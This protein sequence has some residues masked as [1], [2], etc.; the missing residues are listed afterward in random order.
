M[1]INVE[2]EPFKGQRYEPGGLLIWGF[3]HHRRPDEGDTAD[4]TD[5]TINCL[6]L[7][8]KHWFFNR[9]RR[10]FGDKEAHQ[11]W[12]GVAF[13]N[14]LPTAVLSSARFSGGSAEQRG[15]VK[16]RV[17]R[18]LTDLRPGRT[19]LFSTKGW[20]MWPELNGSVPEPAQVLMT[21]PELQYGTYDFGT[22]AEIKAFN[23]P[24]PMFQNDEA[25]TERVHHLMTR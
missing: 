20:P 18:I 4:F 9:I 8:G 3:S 16:Q 19:V 17:R 13:A 22:G 7:S 15:R 12:S 25:M 14:T 11:F 5:R 6:A 21:G 24:H 10:F 23:L 1:P 2:H